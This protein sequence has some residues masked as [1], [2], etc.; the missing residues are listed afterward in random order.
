M[1]I[2]RK[3]MKEYI[4][5]KFTKEGDFDFMRDKLPEVIDV[6]IDLDEAYIGSLGE[7]DDYDDDAVY[8]AIF[9]ELQRRFPDY[10]MY[11][12]R[13]GGLPRFRGGVPRE[14]RR[15]RVGVREKIA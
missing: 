12:M 3:Q 5:D 7:N 13:L 14:H 11:C 6:M 4:L 1:E 8:D 10:K 15:D 2:D 9:P